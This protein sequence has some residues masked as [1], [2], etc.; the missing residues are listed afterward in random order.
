MPADKPVWI[1]EIPKC[2]PLDK[3]FQAMDSYWENE[4]LLLR[5]KSPTWLSNTRRSVLKLYTYEQ[6]KV[7]SAGYVY[8]FIHIHVYVQT[9]AIIKK[10]SPWVWEKCG[11][12]KRG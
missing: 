1:E 6:H 8:V 5:D 7:G 9:L 3:G 12:Y 10:N 11:G 4:S 2:S